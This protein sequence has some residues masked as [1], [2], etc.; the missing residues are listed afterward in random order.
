MP[1]ALAHG[2][3]ATGDGYLHRPGHSPWPI[4]SRDSLAY[5]TYEPST[6]TAGL[7]SSEA[8]LTALN[9]PSATTYTLSSG[10]TITGKIIYGKVLPPATG[11]AELRN[12]LILGSPNALTS[13]ND[14]CL[15]M[16]GAHTGIVRLYDCE[17]RPQ[18]ESAGRN[19][20]L[21]GNFELFRCW[22]HG[23]EDGVGI[24]PA[25]GNGTAANVK[26]KGCLI[27]DMAYIYPDRDHSDGSH[28]DGIQIQGGT[29]IEVVGN[30]IKGTGHRMAG[31]GTFY[32]ANP[33]SSNGDWPLTKSPALCPGSGLIIQN[34]VSAPFD[35]TVIIDANWFRYGGKTML[36][37][38]ST[39]NNFQCTS[40]RFSALNPP[41]SNVNGT[42]VGGV[43]LAFTYNPYFIR[44]DAIGTSN[45][46][47]GLVSSGVLANTTNVWLD[48]GSA[49][50][51]L[52][53]PRASGVVSDA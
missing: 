3:L 44:F 52:T 24:Y 14:G 25:S 39:A 13:G 50:A 26:V 1:T 35:S 34:N 41:G 5:G 28:A 16:T 51:A 33:T 38:K 40:N 36:L 11:D 22:L 12:C 6:T 21:G 32:T 37:I 42:V 48:G 2:W 27:E 7:T 47:T 43:T 10:E 23:G 49:G 8:S 20:I 45:N 9:S 17:I 29:N 19:C 46:I 18:A 31:S 15:T 4:A 30:A 53:T